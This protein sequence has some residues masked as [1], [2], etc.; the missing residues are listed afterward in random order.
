MSD[1]SDDDIVSKKKS[2]G[3]KIK[4]KKS[5]GK[6]IQKK[7]INYDSGSDNDDDKVSSKKNKKKSSGKK[8]NLSISYTKIMK[9]IKKIFHTCHTY[10][11][12][13]DYS[14][15][16]YTMY[17]VLGS[18]CVIVKFTEDHDYDVTYLISE[19]QKSCTI[20]VVVYIDSLEDDDY[21]IKHAVS[22]RILSNPL[23]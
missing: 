21:I 15:S 12:S 5:S 8:D 13:S 6:K 11:K 17:D 16:D 4:K 9:I 23:E 20:P 1:I 3:K 18:K 2:S 14:K 10:R 7:K 22:D 19:S